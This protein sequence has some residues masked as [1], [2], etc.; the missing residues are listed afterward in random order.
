MTAIAVFF[1]IW[2]LYMR[3][4]CGV[5]AFRNQKHGIPNMLYV[6]YFIEKKSVE[7]PWKVK[8]FE[9]FDEIQKKVNIS[10]EDSDHIF[11]ANAIRSHDS[12]FFVQVMSTTWVQQDPELCIVFVKLRWYIYIYLISLRGTLVKLVFRVD[13]FSSF[14]WYSVK[15]ITDLK[16]GPTAV[17]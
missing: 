4:L 3:D 5:L 15:K 7:I 2:C 9:Y 16:V 6:P 1:F 14:V 8:S 17:K 13:V 10:Y 12:H 11:L